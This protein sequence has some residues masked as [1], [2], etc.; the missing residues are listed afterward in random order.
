M[1][2]EAPKQPGSEK[3]QLAPLAL[4]EQPMK[5]RLADSQPTTR[6]EVLKDNFSYM[7]GR[8]AVEIS[9]VYALIFLAAVV[10]ALVNPAFPFL[11]QTNLSGVLSESIPVLAILAIG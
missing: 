5:R 6:M 7:R 3:D 8:G 1:S 2:I 9:V 4:D 11:S 10:T